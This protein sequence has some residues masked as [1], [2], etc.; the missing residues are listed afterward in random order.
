MPKAKR[1]ARGGGGKHSYTPPKWRFTELIFGLGDPTSISR[2][3]VRRGY[4]EIPRSS[5]TGWRVRNSIPPF[6][7]PLF[8]QMALDAKFIN[9]IEDLRVKP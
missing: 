4:P 2:E 1:A 8:I 6:W 3:V 9:S 7:L 5:I